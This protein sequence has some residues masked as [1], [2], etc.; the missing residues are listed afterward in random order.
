MEDVVGGGGI[1]PCICEAERGGQSNT[2]IPLQHLNIWFQLTENVALVCV[3][4]T[5]ICFESQ[6]RRHLFGLQVSLFP[7]FT[8]YRNRNSIATPLE[9][10]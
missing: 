10:L 7:S 5:D 6:P 8:P 2:R 9:R 4:S 3:C 1:A